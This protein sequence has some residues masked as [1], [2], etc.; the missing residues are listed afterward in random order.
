M[1]AEVLL[2][3][4]AMF[5]SGTLFAQ[6]APKAASADII[7]AKGEKIGIANLR[8]T[9]RGVKIRLNASGLPEGTHAFHI[10]AVGKCD[11]PDFKSAGPHFNPSGKKHGT[12]N[13]EGSHAGDL[14]NIE[15]GKDGRAKASALATGVT[16]GDGENSLFHRDGTALVIH[17]KADDYMTDPAGNAGARIACGVIKQ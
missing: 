5:A 2:A 13:P 1:K 7:N 16:L 12:K 3:L 17:E 9:R 14:P 4:T 6:S 11:T 15:V 8:Q 10:H